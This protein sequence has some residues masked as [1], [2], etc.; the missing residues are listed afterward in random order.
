[1]QAV[2]LADRRKEKIS[3]RK[4]VISICLRVLGVLLLPL[5]VHWAITII[6]LHK[7]WSLVSFFT[8]P[9]VYLFW[10]IVVLL[11]VAMALKEK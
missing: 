9:Y 1:M 10:G 2:N 5:L 11:K 4:T 3:V 8:N 6:I 7:R